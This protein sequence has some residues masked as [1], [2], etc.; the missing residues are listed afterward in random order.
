MEN[1]SVL[2]QLSTVS[3]AVPWTPRDVGWG[4]ALTDAE[5]LR[6]Y[7]LRELA[8]LHNSMIMD[9]DIPTVVK[10][11]D[12]AVAVKRVMRALALRYPQALPAFDQRELD[13]A[14]IPQVRT[15]GS[16]RKFGT[17]GTYK[18]VLAAMF[19][20]GRR[21][22]APIAVVAERLETNI[23]NAQVAVNVASSPSRQRDPLPIRYFRDTKSVGRTD[24]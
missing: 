11:S 7:K 23:R 2:E 20:P 22:R 19:P 13:A 24:A 8:T 16:H 14:V 21:D 15:R 9:I 17:R 12:K 18:S 1:Q 10:F 5:D 3:P 6:R 4:L